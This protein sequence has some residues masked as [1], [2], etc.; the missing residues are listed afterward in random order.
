MEWYTPPAIFFALGLTFDLDVC[1]PRGGLP[2][3]PAAEAYWLPDRDGLALPWNGR[4]WMNPP[5]GPFTA[6]WMGRFLEHGNGLALVFAR[7]GTAWAQRA[8]SEA[9]A[10]C[11]LAKRVRFVRSDGRLSTLPS[12]QGQTVAGADSMLLAC[13]S[14]NADALVRSR[15]GVVLQRANP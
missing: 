12:R 14:D 2:W 9:D 4:V 7:P 10:V 8:L 1:A 3:I 13:G 15:L 5:Y 6:R 11:F